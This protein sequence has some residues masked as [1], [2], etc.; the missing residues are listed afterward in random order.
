MR[1]DRRLTR[2]QARYADAILEFIA[3]NKP[4]VQRHLAQ[5]AGVSEY[6]V[7]RW[8]QDPFIRASIA[9]DIRDS[10]P[11]LVEAM[12]LASIHRAI[13][14]SIADY[15]LQLERQLAIDAET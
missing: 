6:Q 11:I 13:R 12:H 3:V 7:S 9:T 14:G 10:E 1:R 5:H 4:L 15:R 2:K 8:M